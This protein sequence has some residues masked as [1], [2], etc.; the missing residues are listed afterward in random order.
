MPEENIAEQS[1]TES[2]KPQPS[3]LAP[4][5]LDY[6]IGA[7]VV[8]I[9]GAIVFTSIGFFRMYNYSYSDHVVGGDAYNYIILAIRGVGWIAGGGVC[10]L[11]AC[12]FVLLSI[13]SITKR[14]K[15]R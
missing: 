5:P 4:V 15:P 11:L 7:A 14:N 12:V 2:G 6:R 10:A 13:R 9:I 1:A 3:L 8:F